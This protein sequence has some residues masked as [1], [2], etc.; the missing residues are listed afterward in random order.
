MFKA[1]EDTLIKYKR[2]YV[3]LKGDKK[4]RLDLAVKYIDNL[5]KNK[6]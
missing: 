2:P 6:K 3:L 4:K 5:L 1:L